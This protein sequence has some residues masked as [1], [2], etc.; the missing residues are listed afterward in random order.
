MICVSSLLVAVPPAKA[1]RLRYFAVWSYTEN[2]PLEEISE[3]RLSDRKLGYWA[4]EF[5][6][7][8]EV[9]GGTYHAADGG[10]WI[11]LRYVEESGRVY[12]D[13][14]G[15]DGQLRSRK[16]TRLV[17]RRPRWDSRE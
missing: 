6:E 14:F 11:S 3:G 17:D 9:L 16:S 15:P 5:D 4:L 8:G 12:A 7:K 10:A 2:A 1:A 13:L